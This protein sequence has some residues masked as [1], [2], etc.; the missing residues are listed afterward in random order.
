MKEFLPLL[1]LLLLI[2]PGSWNLLQ[3]IFCLEVP[4]MPSVGV[5]RYKFQQY[6]FGEWHYFTIHASDQKT[7]NARAAEKFTEMFRSR[8]TIMKQFWPV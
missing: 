6:P 8:Q 4:T 1:L 3:K 5:Y 7:A 2:L